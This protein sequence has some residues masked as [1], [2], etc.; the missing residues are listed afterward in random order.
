[1]LKNFERFAPTLPSSDVKL[2]ISVQRG[3]SQDAA[4]ELSRSL[5]ERVAPYPGGPYTLAKAMEQTRLCAALVTA[6]RKSA[7]QFFTNTRR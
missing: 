4:A 1:V 5:G 3:C 7:T 2:L 6:Q